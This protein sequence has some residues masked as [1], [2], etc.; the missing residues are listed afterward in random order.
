MASNRSKANLCVVRTP[1]THRQA[2]FILLFG[3]RTI[4]SNGS[5]P[6]VR[7][8]C[9]KCGRESDLQSKSYRSW[10]TI[11]FVPVFPLSGKHAL[12]QCP[13]CGAQFRVSP[14][15]IRDRLLAGS[16]QQNQQAIAMYNS[17]RT[18]PANSITLDQLLKLYATMQEY[19]QAISAGA[20][21]QQALH[22]SEQCMTTL[23]RVYLAKND[24]AEALKWFD[25]AIDRNPQLGEAQY[26]K[27]LSHLLTTP[28]NVAAAVA[29]ARAARSAG[30]PEADA[31]L[32][33]A[34]AKARAE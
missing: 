9:P 21:F 2:G 10:F 20:E 3:S 6:P 22:N 7:T 28:P 14:E 34:E 1:R 16:R 12:S 15:E 8:V 23:G 27:G 11:F 17:L 32:R 25:S 5:S 33:Q 29:A 4:V 30:Y 13:L 31:L 19:D 18:S 24:Y 26:Y